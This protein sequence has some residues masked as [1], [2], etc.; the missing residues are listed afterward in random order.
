M[1]ASARKA[2]GAVGI[3]VFL[4]IYVVAA[5]MIG[6]QLHAMPWAALAFYG[7]AGVAWVFP[8]R[9]LFAWMHAKAD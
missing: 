4:V 5:V 2:I 1:S 3:L 8:L 6:E 9:P 7:I